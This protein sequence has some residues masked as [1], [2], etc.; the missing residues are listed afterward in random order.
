MTK[1]EKIQSHRDAVRRHR[2]KHGNIMIQPTL[3]EMEA[4]KVA[5]KKSCLS[6]RGYALQAVREKMERD[7]PSVEGT[8]RNDQ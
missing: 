1:D 7:Q 8:A 3:D 2:E 4:I 5:A 6:I